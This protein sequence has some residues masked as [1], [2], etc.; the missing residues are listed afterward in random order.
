MV[1]L[2][3][4]YVEGFLTGAGLIMAIGAQ[5]VF[6][7]TQGVRREHHVAVAL[8]CAVCD[9]CLITAGLA[10]VGTALAASP[11]LQQ[12][13]ALG[14]AVFLG[15]Y[16]LRAARDAWRGG[17]GL[18]AAAAQAVRRS[19]GTVLWAALAVTL[20]N[21]HVYLDTVLLLGSIGGQHAP[22]GRW[23]FGAGAATASVLWFVALAACGRL[24]SPVLARPAAWRVLNAVVAGIMWL[25]AAGLVRLGLGDRAAYHAQVLDIRLILAQPL[26]V[27]LGCGVGYLF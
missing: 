21:P 10:G 2:S 11:M 22:P 25:V 15:W 27:S 18:E 26:D 8:L 12:A 19:L 6:V 13:A 23:R 3:F 17:A 4:P 16:G 14:G 20:L 24:L 1:P 9:A 5:N 7:L